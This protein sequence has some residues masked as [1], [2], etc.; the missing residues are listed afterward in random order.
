MKPKIREVML[1]DMLRC[2]DLNL[3]MRRWWGINCWENYKLRELYDY[4]SK[5]Q[6]KITYYNH[7]YAIIFE[8]LESDSL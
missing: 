5:I 2:L 3:F 4:L 7:Y 1:T 8:I 6:E